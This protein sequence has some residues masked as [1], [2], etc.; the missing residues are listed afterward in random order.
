MTSGI[1]ALVMDD[2]PC[3]IKCCVIIEENYL[4]MA[5]SGGGLRVVIHPFISCWALT[6]G[7]QESLCVF[8]YSL[9]YARKFMGNKM[10]I[11]AALDVD[12]SMV[13][14]VAIGL[15]A[16]FFKGTF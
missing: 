8:C 13:G 15:P 4:K 7:V 14:V 6:L 3:S 2:V 16:T 5:D 11:G 10:F 9:L 1:Q 12:V